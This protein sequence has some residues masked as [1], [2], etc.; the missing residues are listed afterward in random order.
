VSKYCATATLD[1]NFSWVTSPSRERDGF[2][3]HAWLYLTY[4]SV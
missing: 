1:L 4:V 3:N 2:S